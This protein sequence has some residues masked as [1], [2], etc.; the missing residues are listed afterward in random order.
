MDL[1][2]NAGRAAKE[3][4]IDNSLADA[5]TAAPERDRR[6]IRRSFTDAERLRS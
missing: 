5:A 6:S 2:V 4:L 3:R 1:R